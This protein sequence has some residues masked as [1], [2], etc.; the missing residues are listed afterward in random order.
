MLKNCHTDRQNVCSVGGTP[1]SRASFISK[2]NI[3]SGEGKGLADGRRGR[4]LSLRSFHSLGE[5]AG[6]FHELLTDCG[7]NCLGRGER[8]INWLIDDPEGWSI[9]LRDWLRNIVNK[10]YNGT[11][12]KMDE[13]VFFRR[14]CVLSTRPVS[15]C[16]VALILIGESW[17]EK[18]AS[19]IISKK[20]ILKGWKIVAF[21]LWL[22]RATRLLWYPAKFFKPRWMK[23]QKPNQ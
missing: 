9:D 3:Y 15:C 5:Q 20:C 11:G 22:S 8:Q 17:F 4:R 13:W 21:E 23:Q 18:C 10:Q 19:S 1:F 16:P 6:E 2:I 14:K 12:E 7:R